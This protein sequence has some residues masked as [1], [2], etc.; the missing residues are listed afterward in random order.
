MRNACVLIMAIIFL[1]ILGLKACQKLSDYADA[2][3]A[4]Q[5]ALWDANVSPSVVR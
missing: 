3:S 5:K 2:Y 4:E 1:S